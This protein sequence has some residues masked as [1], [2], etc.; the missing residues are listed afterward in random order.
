MAMTQAE[1]QRAYRERLKESGGKRLFMTISKDDAKLLMMIG[2]VNFP[3][4][5][6]DDSFDAQELLRM[7]FVAAGKRTLTQLRQARYLKE[8]H[9]ASD[10]VIEKYNHQHSYAYREGLV[11]SADKYMENREEFKKFLEGAE[12]SAAQS[13]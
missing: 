6:I 9:N 5:V 2:K 11:T 13:N 3:E 12:N 4:F 1:K 7:I 8:N 10:E